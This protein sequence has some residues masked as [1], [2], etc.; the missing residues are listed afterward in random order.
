[1]ASRVEQYIVN[2][3][4]FMD[5]EAS[6]GQRLAISPAL[7]SLAPGFLFGVWILVTQVY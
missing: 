2:R 4:R 1:M 7:L 6:K 3:R 5:A